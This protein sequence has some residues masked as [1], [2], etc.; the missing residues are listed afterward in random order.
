MLVAPAPLIVMPTDGPDLFA[1]VRSRLL[2]LHAADDLQPESDA[3][4]VAEAI[5]GARVEVIAASGHVLPDDAPEA[6]AEAVRRF[7]EQVP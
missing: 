3:R 1:L 6:F 7:L 5:P 2:V 4:V